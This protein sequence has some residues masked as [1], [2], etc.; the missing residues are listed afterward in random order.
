MANLRLEKVEGGV[1][2]SVKVLAGSSRTALSGLLDGRLK[3]KV[4]AAAEKG[5]ANR[6]LV[7]FL[8]ERLGV[9]K[10]AVSIIAGRTKP[11]KKVQVL[12]ISVETLLEKLKL[13]KQ[14]LR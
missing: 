12:G 10:N 14:G 3:I 4:G 1:F 5:E 6:C 7:E 8:A 11:V 9:K 13:N 2:F